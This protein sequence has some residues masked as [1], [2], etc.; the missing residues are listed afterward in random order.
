MQLSLSTTGINRLAEKASRRPNSVRPRKTVQQHGQQLQITVARSAL[1]LLVCTRPAFSARDGRDDPKD[2]EGPSGELDPTRDGDNSPSDD[3][4]GQGGSDGDEQ[5]QL[6][7]GGGDPVDGEDPPMPGGGSGSDGQP[8]PWEDRP[9]DECDTPGMDEYNQR[10]LEQDVVV[11]IDEWQKGRGDA[12]GY[13]KRFADEILRSKVD[14]F[15]ALHAALKYAVT[16]VNGLGDYARRKLA[17]RQPPGST[18]LP[19][20]IKPIPRATVIVDTSGSMG[21]KLLARSFSP[22][23]I[24]GP[25]N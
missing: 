15:E 11:K 19:A 12:P 24:V 18:R 1:L 8:R 25:G 20:P 2:L 21:S 13:I 14:P 10:M 16:A 22:G 17:R 5:D 4:G 6:Q 3:P 7:P 9:S 23:S